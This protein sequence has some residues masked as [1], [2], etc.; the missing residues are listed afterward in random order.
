MS[1]TRPR[2]ELLRHRAPGAT[3]GSRT[4]TKAL[5]KVGY[6]CNEHC[7]F[8]HTLEVRHIQG[9]TAEVDGKIRRAAELG[10]EMVVLS[11]GE[12]TIRP[13]LVHWA[14]LTASLGLD[15]GLVTNGQMLAYPE[16]VEKLIARRLRYVYLSLHG[17][18]RK[19]HNLMVRSDAFD[20]AY[21][22][23]ENL[24][25]RGLDLAVNCVIT[26]HNVE[27][28][29]GLVDAL[30]P[31]ADVEV[32]FSMVEPKGGGDKLFDHLMPRVEL[33]AKRVMEAI[34]Y[35]DRRVA[36]LGQ[37][38][39]TFSHGAIP[40]CLLPGYEDR[41]D[42]LKTHA[43]RTMIEVGEPDFFPVDDLNKTHADRCHGCALRGPCPGLYNGY[44]EVYGATE[45]YP[46]RDRPRSNSYNYKLEKLVSLA[47][48][49]ETHDDCLLRRGVGVTP[50]DRG[51]DLFVRNGKRVA[52]FRAQ[53]RDFSDREIYAIK[54]DLG[55]LYLDVSR[56]DAPDDFARDL[57]QLARSPLCEGCPSFAECTGMFEPVFEDVFT[58]DDAKV[59]EVLASL[60][61]EVL[62][63]GCGEGPYESI[64]APL[65]EAGTIRYLGVD[66]HAAAIAELRQRWPWAELRCTGGEEL[67]LD[68]E[69]RFD[70]VLILR[71]WNHLREP[72][73]IL[74]QLLPR[75]RPGGTLTIVDNVAFGLARTRD[76]TQRAERSRAQFEHY[77]NDSLADAARVLE[78][79]GARFG[80]AEIARS[81]VGPRTSNQWLLRVRVS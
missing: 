43:Y 3:P 24:S 11:G 34:S 81:T 7:S 72:E 60:R 56:K 13:E 37:R 14:S 26:R 66:P 39:P 32:K 75:V 59:R 44:H 9:S 35:G 33:V 63:L 74:D 80:L 1:D 58:R 46:R 51:R 18:T 57:V 76:Q 45:L 36:E 52:R 61:G 54:H 23:V 77:R 41:F 30:L 65:A 19:I 17:G 47:F 10:H 67:E 2:P 78:P 12:P 71:A 55:Q 31:Y 22:A 49:G 53:S 15:F 73:R 50:W 40:L 16:V 62:D 8:C 68:P 38:G 21:K 5:I 27:H 25:G 48:E 70:H 28:L 6:A 42:D 79:F 4:G 69:R 64:L 29:Q 20:A